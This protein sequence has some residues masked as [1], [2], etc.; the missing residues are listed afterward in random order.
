VIDALFWLCAFGATYSYFLYP[1]VLR[2]LP[3]RRRVTLAAP[4][5]SEA[6]LP[7]LTL[8]V[9]AHNEQARIERK[10]ANT[11]ALDYPR[12]RL[13]VIVASD[14]S[15]DATDAIVRRHESDGVQLVRP[16]ERLGKE[17]AQGTAIAASTGEILVFSDVATEIPP[18]ALR[19]IAA[20]FAADP[21][22]GAISSEDRFISRNGEIA[23][24]GAYVRYEMWLRK[25]ESERAGLVGL[26][27]SFF[28]ARR[29][30]CAAWDI[31]VPSDFNTALNCARLGRCAISHPEVLGFY[32]DVQDPSR[33]Y[34][35]KVRTVL[36][37]ITAIARHPNVLSPRFGTFALQVWSHKI[38]LALLPL[39][40][41]LVGTHPVYGLAALAQ[42]GFYG[43]ALAG[44][45]SPRLRALLPVR[46]VYFFVQVNLAIADAT[47]QFL[48]GQ[49]M[50]VW[51]PTVR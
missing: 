9:T 37:G 23:G 32:E 16:A 51:S 4:S 19:R 46:I 33:E 40:A 44:H 17:N 20:G 22:I 8:I 14:A 26:S 48:R 1:L 31:H 10:L 50:T 12:D 36:R 15:T 13:Q 49:R 2:C 41:L 34:L 28:A 29:E 43:V 6:A 5:L 25:L 27:G 42:A 39:N 18:D 45:L 38:M 21:G 30:V 11:L 7:T 35:R 3:V 24:E 47:Q